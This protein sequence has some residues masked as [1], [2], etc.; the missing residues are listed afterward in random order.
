MTLPVRLQPPEPFPET[1]LLKR[2]LKSHKCESSTKT[3]PGNGVFHR[4]RPCLTKRPAPCGKHYRHRG[5]H[6]GKI[7][8]ESLI[9]C[10]DHCC[11]PTAFSS[12]RRWPAQLALASRPPG[13]EPFHRHRCR[14]H[15]ATTAIDLLQGR[16]TS[17]HVPARR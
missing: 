6:W 13:L 8:G 12:P 1:D 15:E 14:C 5:E 4:N 17:C 2:S 16:P 7:N 11:C 10:S 9:S 3:T